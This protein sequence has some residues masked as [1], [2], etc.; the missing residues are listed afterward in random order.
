MPCRLAAHDN[1]RFEAEKTSR[2]VD[3]VHSHAIPFSGVLH[4]DRAHDS[5]SGW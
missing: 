5:V 3:A 4:R 1:L 2:N